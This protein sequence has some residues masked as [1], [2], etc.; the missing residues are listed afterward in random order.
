VSDSI[1]LKF[2]LLA[3]LAKVVASKTDKLVFNIKLD[4]NFFDYFPG[5]KFTIDDTNRLLMI[6]KKLLFIAPKLSF[7]SLPIPFSRA[8]WTSKNAIDLMLAQPNHPCSGAIETLS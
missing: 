5:R 4:Q 7:S 1:S 2:P 6:L 3:P 8:F